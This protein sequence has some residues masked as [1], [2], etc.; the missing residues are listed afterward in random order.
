[1][2]TS[3]PELSDEQIESMRFA[4][5][6]DVDKSARSKTRRYRQVVLGA[7][8]VIALG[9]I[10]TGVIQSYG[11]SNSV[12]ASSQK[13]GDASRSGG[14]PST[15]YDNAVPEGQS[16]DDSAGKAALDAD[17]EVITTGSVGMTVADPVDTATKISTWVSTAGGRVDSR[18]ETASKDDD[19]GSVHLLIRIP[20]SKV[21]GSIDTFRTYG[22]IEYVNIED[23]DVTTQGQDLDARINA[24]KISVSRLESLMKDA[25]STNELLRAETALTERQAELD[26]L[27]SQRKHL[28]DQ[29][30]L[31][32]ITIDLAA[33]ASA[34]SPSADG[35]WGGVV[36]GWNGLVSTIEGAVHTLGVVL[37]WALVLG[38]LGG[39]VWLVTRRRSSRA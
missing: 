28:S 13:E 9:G 15:Q 19:G 35:F 32:A 4:I 2:N 38:A 11:E 10:G 5:M 23:T 29:V 34:N 3:I 25:N 36:A 26:S 16:A 17:R 14:G 31:S 27:V 7:A 8:T 20:Q 18:S 12:T 33:K 21:D 6:S 24:L 37:P 30:D 22:T 1:M 39:I